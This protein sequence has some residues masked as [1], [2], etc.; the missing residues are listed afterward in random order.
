MKP[1]DHKYSKD[2]RNCYGEAHASYKS[3][4]KGKRRKNRYDRRLDRQVGGDGLCLSDIR[5][6]HRFVKTPD[7]SAELRERERLL[8]DVLR[9]AESL[10]VELAF[11]TQTLNLRQEEPQGPSDADPK[12]EVQARE[13]GRTAARAILERGKDSAP[14]G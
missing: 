10:G 11:P 5:H 4:A 8:L 7:W 6:K 2:R 9:L 3:I 1:D 13:E 14:S 12:G